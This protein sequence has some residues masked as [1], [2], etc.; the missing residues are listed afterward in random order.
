VTTK[1]TYTSGQRV[2][3]LDVERDPFVIC[4]MARSRIF[5]GEKIKHDPNFERAKITQLEAKGK[6][7][8]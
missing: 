8:P 7:M 5:P 6:G 4:E 1:I 3:V 2:M